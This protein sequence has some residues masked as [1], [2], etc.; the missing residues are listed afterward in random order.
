MKGGEA[1]FTL[2]LC[3]CFHILYNGLKVLVTFPILVLEIFHLRYSGPLMACA[4]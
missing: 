3:S 2:L 1:V 4:P